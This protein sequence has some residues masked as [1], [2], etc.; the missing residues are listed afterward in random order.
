MDSRNDSNHNIQNRFVNFG[1][2]F[3]SISGGSLPQL[4]PLVDLESKDEPQ[5]KVNEQNGD[6][7]LPNVINADSMIVAEDEEIAETKKPGRKAKR[8]KR[9]DISSNVRVTRSRALKS[10]SQSDLEMS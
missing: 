1:S 3:G 2:N 5:S 6:E 10:E 4:E 9:R 8:V 7:N